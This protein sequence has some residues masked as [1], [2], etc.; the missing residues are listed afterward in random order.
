MN[1]MFSILALMSIINYSS[2][3]P[4][5]GWSAKASEF[6]DI[7]VN[8][9]L[10]IKVT[11]SLE[12][13]LTVNNAVYAAGIYYMY[14]QLAPN[15]HNRIKSM[16][17]YDNYTQEINRIRNLITSQSML[18]NWRNNTWAVAEEVRQNGITIRQQ[19][20]QTQSGRSSYIDEFKNNSPLEKRD[21]EDRDCF[22]SRKAVYI[23]PKASNSY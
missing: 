21:L 12:K 22:N 13:R 17:S 11:A 8:S 19:M 20:Q 4:F 16:V 18:F 7:L 23:F 15:V 9:A 2:A 3:S 14:T 5:S 10:S 1:K 6:K